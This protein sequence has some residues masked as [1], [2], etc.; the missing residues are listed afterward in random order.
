MDGAPSEASPT[1]GENWDIFDLYINAR[2]FFDQSGAERAANAF[3]VTPDVVSA[4]FCQP[5]AWLLVNG[6]PER[7][8]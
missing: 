7:K 3:T 1:D 6:D 4:L 2:S 5:Y 8:S